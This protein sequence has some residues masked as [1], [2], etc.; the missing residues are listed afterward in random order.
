MSTR[1]ISRA[2][3]TS[4]LSMLFIAILALRQWTPVLKGSASE[5]GVPRV[6]GLAH[7]VL[8]DGRLLGI[9]G[10]DGSGQTLA[11][12]YVTDQSGIETV[13]PWRL[14]EARAF[15]T[16]TV[17][18]DG[19]VL[20]LGG[21][22]AGGLATTA[23]L[24]DT[25]TGAVESVTVPT[26]FQRAR[27]TTTLLTDGSLVV[28]GGITAGGA[29]TDTASWNIASNAWAP[30]NLAPGQRRH[31]HAAQLDANGDIVVTGGVCAMS[32]IQAGA[33]VYH[34][35]THTVTSGAPADAPAEIVIA[36]SQPAE[37]AGDV[38]ADARIAIRF[39]APLT[40]ATLNPTTVVLRGSDG[41][42][43]ARVVAAEG[44]RLL[45]VTPDRPLE[46]GSRYELSI[47][48]AQDVTGAVVAEQ[49]VT[50]TTAGEPRATS[51]A[52]SDEDSD[53]SARDSLWRKLPPLQGRPGRTALAGQALRLNGSP[54]AGVKLELAGH[55]ATTDRTG[56]FLLDADGEPTGWSELWIDGR[57]ARGK[58][59]TYGTYEVG[60]LL[61]AKKTSALPFTIWMTKID[62]AHAVT[63]PSP[64]TAETIVTTPAIPQL[65]LHIPAGATI[66]DHEGHVVRRVSITAIPLDRPPFPLP[67]GVDVPIYFTIQP[68]GAYVEVS[69]T[70][71]YQVGAR[72]MYPNYK[73][74]PRGT[75]MEFWHYEADEG[76]GW[77]V[78]GRG[79]VT[80][81]GRQVAPDPGVS[82][83]EFTGAMVAPPT[84][85]PAT[86]P[87]LGGRGTGGD[88]VDLGTGLFIL[89]NTDLQLP[90]VLPISLQRTYRPNDTV[91]RS[92]GIGASHVFDMFLVGTTFPYT[93]Q[94][95]IL[96]D[97]ARVHYD[98]VSPGT[99]WTDAVYE[100]TSSETAFFKSRISW[101]GNGWNLDLKDGSRIVFREAFGAGLPAQAGATRI[102]DRYGNAI[103]LTRNGD[104]DLTQI[105]SPNGR[106]IALTYDTSH[107]ITD[108]RDNIGRLVHYTYNAGGGLATV[109]DVRGGV[110][111][112]TYDAAG[113]M[114][115]IKDARNIV[116]LTN[117]YDA[118]GRVITQT[119]ADQSTFH[120]AYT[121]DGTGRITQTEVT[122]PRT[123]VRRM[124][125][126]SVGYATSDMRAVGQSEQR[127]TTYEWQPGTNWLL[128]TIDPLNRRTAFTYDAMGNRTSVTRAGIGAAV[129][130]YEP[131]F[132]QVASVTD[133]LTHQTTFDYD[134]R[135]SL[136]KVRD[137]LTHE[138]QFAHNDAGQVTAITD[139]LSHRIELGYDGGLLVR[140][141][142]A[143][144]RVTSRFVDGAGRVLSVTDPLGRMT[145]LDYNAQNRVTRVTDP[146]GGQTSFTYDPNGNL[147]TVT[148]AK[149]HTT[150]YTYDRMDRLATR[151]DP[152]WRNET[153][154][155]DAAGNLTQVTDR[156]NQIM[157]Y[158][159][160]PLNR[161][162][163]ATYEDDTT[164]TDTYDA[165]DR[166][167]QV[168][169][170]VAG[171]IIRAYDLLDRLTT[172]T[173]PQGSVGYTYD[174]ASRRKTMT[175]AGQPAVN[176]TYDDADRLT[177]ITQA[178]ASVSVAYDET[179]RRTS[180]T[181]PNGIVTGYAYDAASQLTGL[182]YTLGPTTLGDLTYAY[183]AAGNRTTVGGT[184]A[185]TGLPVPLSSATYDAAN[186]VMQSGSTPLSYDANG[187]LTNDGTSIYTWNARN[188][189]TGLT[190]GTSA[191]FAYDGFGRRHGKTI[192]TT[193]TSFLY[194][195]LNLAQELT[196]GGTPTANLLTGPGVDETL[197]RTD[198]SGTSTPLADPLGST[199]AL[200]DASGTVKTQYTYEPFG[201]TTVSG[202][203][204]TSAAQYTGRENDTGG[205]YYYRARFYH[206]GL[207]RFISEDPSG[208]AAG[209]PNLYAYTFNAP[210]RY[211]D[212]SGRFAVP[213][214]LCAAGAGGSA[215]ADWMGG[216]K[217][218]PVKAAMWC[219]AGAGLGFMG[220][221]IAAALEGAGVA[222]AAGV[223]AAGVA[224]ARTVA[225]NLAE[226][227]ALEEA[228]AG[229][230][231]RIM[232]QTIR[233][234]NF[235]QDVY[236]KVQ[237]VHRALD[238]TTIT[239]HYWNNLVTGELTGF[240]FK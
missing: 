163:T 98:R 26:G 202:T 218:D 165:G 124:T 80:P 224:T 133:P 30:W 14:N 205:L 94:E 24:I 8:P 93:W 82:I 51:P 31:S 157:T 153:F 74:R 90:D 129:Y 36:E 7:V 207:Q 227:L 64:T 240:K 225:Q 234:P 210:T 115:T 105:T 220:P 2:A 154:A 199:L 53:P 104:A 160:D 122:D 239:V 109:T 44:G 45:F 11:A 10:T 20:V 110:T 34:T 211:R 214:A 175:V 21:I 125:F 150:T 213:L 232:E 142:D 97:G 76:R 71:G 135:G 116:Y 114:L 233:D 79:E 87:A 1:G 173:T 83:H 39:A 29:W 33:D 168:D 49:R 101:N 171:T 48:G 196:G 12:A 23:E 47:D 178:A 27:H 162:R 40:I 73:G 86:G 9:G 60:V 111:A 190:G 128:A 35:T 231:E 120:F 176:Y 77:Y 96:P 198:G 28:S 54:L 61:T 121:L 222:T 117:E 197:I 55:T 152:L 193:T 6:S 141:T 237:H 238:G 75:R 177:G 22:A 65:E 58:G 145:R 185:R 138:T 192:N 180:L 17:L 223:G 88:P 85:A 38:P 106:W 42:V 32:G 84:L 69:G 37:G 183:D 217:I 182:A 172:E 230:G 66:R 70:R 100:H 194:D 63:I 41:T 158:T 57:T 131:T 143:L 119:L 16:A 186:Q 113:R 102:Q 25:D 226:E 188:Q 144:T 134:A 164:I 95:L 216:R 235:P 200:A 132:Q 62:T 103:T 118:N 92:F 159:Y 127:T 91:S 221:A 112:Y 99:D 187:N 215:A 167:T 209:D 146:I 208:F 126:N 206:P 5:P 130:T 228:M 13:A 89:T 156:K 136:T 81:D 19:R 181:L 166:L 68:G 46:P 72:L 179:N 204:S 4:A 107:R 15:H 108:A 161:R 174:A 195:G 189:L 43:S 229:A 191:S 59:A 139:A 56:R 170:T 203:P 149:D 212:P 137:P 155:Y 3:R 52:D 219:A 148:D 78:Y 201:A 50:F 123:F 67:A 184:W 151:T 169:D 236:A 147:L 18:P 140:Q